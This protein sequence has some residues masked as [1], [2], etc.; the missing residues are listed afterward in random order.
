MFKFF[1]FKINLKKTE[2]WKDNFPCLF[3]REW[4]KHIRTWNCA[5]NY[6][7]LT[8]CKVVLHKQA[9]T[10][11]LSLELPMVGGLG[12]CENVLHNEGWS[13]GILSECTMENAGTSKHQL[14]G[15]KYQNQRFFDSEILQKTRTKGS[16]ICKFSE[17]RKRKRK[18]KLLE[19]I[20]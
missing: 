9:L 18:Q 4:A 13:W 19:K 3:I 6:F 14:F 20:K 16:S 8:K 1:F 11:S 2:I 15:S 17:K 12:Y 7:Q 5:I 10:E